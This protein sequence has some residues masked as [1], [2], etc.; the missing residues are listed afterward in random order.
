M[1]EHY[2]VYLA[3][4]IAGSTYE[5][6]EDWRICARLMLLRSPYI[7]TF[8]PM[9]GKAFLRQ[10]GVLSSMPDDEDPRATG[11]GIMGRDHND[12]KTADAVLMNLLNAERISVGSMIEAAWCYAYRVPLI[13]V[14]QA[15]NIHEHA[16]LNQIP[17]YRTDDLQTGCD[18]V[19][20]LL[21][22]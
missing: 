12:V 13:L 17:T 9:R 10:H 3:G 8:S 4:P 21:L 15:G 16:M 11:P 20:A 14:M 1:K 19:R 22:P 7:V 5:A 6:S 2:K 18:L